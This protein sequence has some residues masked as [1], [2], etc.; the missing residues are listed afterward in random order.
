LPILQIKGVTSVST[1]LNLTSSVGLRHGRCTGNVP[2]S[3]HPTELGSIQSI[4][5]IRRSSC[6][7]NAMTIYLC[8]HRLKQTN[9]QTK[10][11]HNGT[12]AETTTQRQFIVSL[13]PLAVQPRDI[14]STTTMTSS[15]ASTTSTASRRP[16]NITSHH[17]TTTISPF[18]SVVAAAT[19]TTAT[20][21]R[22]TANLRLPRPSP[23]LVSTHEEMNPQRRSSMED[24]TVY[25]AAGTW[26]APDPTMAY[27][28]LYDGHGGT[29]S[30][31]LLEPAPTLSSR[32]LPY[33]YPVFFIRSIATKT[34]VRQAETWSNISSMDFCFIL[35]T[36]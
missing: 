31:I 22:K 5:Q 4:F 13:L 3:I 15:M 9:H 28:G 18:G 34:N 11:S 12:H 1:N 23:I 35:P 20:R 8:K 30:H 7:R 14:R 17:F 16:E 33:I 27:L 29:M 32:L 6:C 2:L 21:H 36:N 19:T 25:A 10:Q 26:D 24:C